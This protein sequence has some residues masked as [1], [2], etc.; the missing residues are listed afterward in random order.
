MKLSPA[1]RFLSSHHWAIEDAIFARLVAVLE[2]HA[3]GDKLDA[4]AI[5]AAIGRDSTAPDAAEP[6]MVI[7]GDTA[8]IP[9]RG[10]MARYADSVNGF[11]QSKGRSS[12]SI[13]SDLLNASSQGVNRIILQMDTPGGEVA[14]TAETARLVSE[15]V[16]SGT[17]VIAYVDGMCASAGYWIASACS[18]I[19]ASAPT[20]IVGSIGVSTTL[21]ERINDDAKQKVHVINSADAKGAGPLNDARLANTRAIVMDLAKSFAEAVAAGRGFDP[22][23][24]AKVTTAEVFTAAQ[25]L[26]LGLVDRIASL[27][28]VI[29]RQ[30]TSP[31]ASTPLNGTLVASATE[32]SAFNANPGEDD[33]KI[34]AQ[35]LATLIAAHALHATLIATRA[36]AGD[37]EGQIRSLIA[38]ADREADQK[39]LATVQKDL[40][41]ERT[42]HASTK[43][44]LEELTAKHTKLTALAA[45]AATDPGT[46]S[47]AADSK[48]GKSIT[49]EAFASMSMAAKE[50]FL[51]QGG[52]IDG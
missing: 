48:T 15:L 10:V 43:K 11:C 33:M 12:E 36:Q 5:T 9:M 28:A 7:T 19:V 49:A 2:R 38:A 4:E 31:A 16:A 52:K 50:S 41:D 45:G 30:H 3:M 25:A 44:M 6:A 39:A 51:Q 35:A 34:T 32:P 40:T 18:E 21:V 26:N 37:D 14:G 46:G 24:L 23:A 42:A 29:G 8:V 20:N 27:S 47:E 22:T 17:E 13:Q 1:L